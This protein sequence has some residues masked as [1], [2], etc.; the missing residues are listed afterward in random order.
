MYAR[1]FLIW[2]S[3]DPHAE[4]Y[5]SISPYAYC[6]GNPVSFFDPNGL[7]PASVLVY[8][9]NDG[10]YRFTQSAACLLSLVSG[11]SRFYIEN[12]IIQE[13][14]VGHYLPSYSSN[15]GG[16]AITLGHSSYKATITYTQNYFADDPTAYDNHGY[17]QN[18]Q[19]WLGISAHEVG[20]I[21]QIDEAGGLFSYVGEMV[22][23]YAQSGHNDAPNE[24]EADKGYTNFTQFN[25]FVNKTYGSGAL[26]DLFNSKTTE[27]KKTSTIEKWYGAFQDQKQ[28]ATK[29][30]MNNFKN[31]E[32]GTYKWDGTNWVKQ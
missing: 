6:E 13:R 16:G 28:Q 14:G 21:P 29:S 5:Y 26:T 20:H 18:I 24:K 8:N 3:V 7:Y 2:T 23:Q 11:V 12:V 27:S 10:K 30:F 25:T 32:S 1:H 4:K 17:G 22:K 31:Q 9:P 15:N 19:E